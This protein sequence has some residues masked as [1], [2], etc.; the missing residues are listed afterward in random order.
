MRPPDELP[1]DEPRP[2]DSAPD[3][4]PPGPPPPEDPLSSGSLV[5]PIDPEA[6]VNL[7]ARVR[8]G[9]DEALNRLLER[10]LPPLRRYAHMRLPSY[11]RGPLDTG[12]LVQDTVI[13]ALRSL[14]G[15]EARREGALQCYLCTALKN[16]ITD[17]R[18]A[19]A[20]RPLFVE[21]PESIATEGPSPLEQIIGSENL[22]RYEA[23]LKKLDE[24]DREAIICRIELQY[25][26]AELATAL[27]KRSPDAARMALRRAVD[28]LAA[29]MDAR[30]MG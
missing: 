29:A 25:S 19:Y 6:T 2:D 10:C 27:G 3:D 4:L 28:R 20:R 17:L 24:D 18:R 1:P 9:D 12:D 8:A 15:F 5:A 30:G 22:D 26:F 11:L 14:N 21:L 13:A 7:L 16:K 23:G